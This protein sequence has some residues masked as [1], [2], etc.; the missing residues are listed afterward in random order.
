MGTPKKFLIVVDFFLFFSKKCFTIVDQDWFFYYQ[1]ISEHA[2]KHLALHV[3]GRYPENLSV[4][5]SS[6]FQAA[7]KWKYSIGI[8]S[9]LTKKSHTRLPKS[10]LNLPRAQLTFGQ[11][12]KSLCS[13]HQGDGGMSGQKQTDPSVVFIV[14]LVTLL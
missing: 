2:L 13:P 5:N 14:W 10:K 4:E 3:C 8:F 12:S 7:H 1:Y 11:A 6:K 9:N